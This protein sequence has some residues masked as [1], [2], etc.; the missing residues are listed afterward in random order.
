MPGSDLYYAM[1]DLLQS[2]IS[3]ALYNF[4]NAARIG[5]GIA[6]GVVGVSVIFG[7]VSDEITRIR[8]KRGI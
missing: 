3:G 7:I 2:N 6:V 4:M 1:R 8:K 5:L